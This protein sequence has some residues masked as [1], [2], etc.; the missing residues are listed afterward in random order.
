VISFIVPAYNEERLLGRTLDAIHAAARELAC[1]YELIVV[2]DGSTDRTAS[3]AG[4]AGARVVSVHLRQISRVRN[5]GAAV[6]TG[7][8]LFFVDADT[9]L[10]ART[11]RAAND[12]IERGAVGGGASVYI[13]GRLPIGIRT[14]M[15]MFRA[16]FRLTR[17]AAGCCLFCSRRAFEAVGGFDEQLFAAEEIALSRALARRGPFVVLREAVM[18]SGRKVRTHT[19]AE[20]VRLLIDFLRHGTGMLKTRDRLAIWYG[21]RRDDI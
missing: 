17:L 12:A 2:D 18:T 8:V 11:L 21:E 19:A 7:E 9:I 13:D 3:I 16:A 15:V 14:F 10:P 4:A 5:A 20:H 6:A 1:R